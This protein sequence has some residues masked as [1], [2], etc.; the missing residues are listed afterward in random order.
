MVVRPAERVTHDS[1]HE[2]IVLVCRE[3]ER[4]ALRQDALCRAAA[5]VDRRALYPENCRGH[6]LAGPCRAAEAAGHRASLLRT[7]P[8]RCCP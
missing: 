7:A 1:S 3:E 2:T 8:C 4:R 5:A 6:R